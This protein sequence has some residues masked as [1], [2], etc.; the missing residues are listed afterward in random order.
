MLCLA[1][2]KQASELISYLRYYQIKS[3]HNNMSRKEARVR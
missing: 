3:A 2:T 1:L